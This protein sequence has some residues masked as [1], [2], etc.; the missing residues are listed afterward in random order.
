MLRIEDTDLE[1]STKASE[2]A[3]LEDLIWLGLKWDEGLFV[4]F[5]N[6]MRREM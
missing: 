2:E 5:M 6:F 3:L 4:V 1:R